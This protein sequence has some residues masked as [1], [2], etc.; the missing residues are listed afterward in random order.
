MTF[1]IGIFIENGYILSRWM[2][3]VSIYIIPFGAF[4]SG[5]M[6][7]LIIGIKKAKAEI[8]TGA[9]KPLGIWFEPM[10]KYVF[11]LLTLIVLVGGGILGGIG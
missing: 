5:V 8:E 7:F 9:K 10:A 1:L 3:I 11:V 4:I 2:D 6:F